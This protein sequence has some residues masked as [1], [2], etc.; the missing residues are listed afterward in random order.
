MRK[1]LNDDVKGCFG[2]LIWGAKRGAREG[3]WLRG[4]LSGA[5]GEVGDVED[6]GVGGSNGEKL[7]K[8]ER[9]SKGKIKRVLVQIGLN[10]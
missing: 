9:H 8:S 2:K 5:I 10:E 4:G 7:R 1:G 6:G 3:N